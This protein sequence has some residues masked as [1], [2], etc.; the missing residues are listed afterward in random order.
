MLACNYKK[1][2]IRYLNCFE[3]MGDLKCAVVI[4]A[5]DVREGQEDVD[6][7]TDDVVLAFWRRL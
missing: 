4:S 5:P 6:E 3:Q 1:D 7:S 2:A